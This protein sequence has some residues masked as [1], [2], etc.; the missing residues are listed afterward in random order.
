VALDATHDIP[1]GVR[2][3]YG[4]INIDAGRAVEIG[5]VVPFEAADQISRQ[6]SKHLRVGLVDDETAEA[7]ERHAG[8]A[9]LIDHGGD[10]GPHTDHVRVQPE[11]AGDILVDMRVSI[12]Q[13]GQ[14]QLAGNVDHLAGTRRQ[15][16]LCNRSDLAIAD[17]DITEPV[18]LRGRANNAATS[19]QEIIFRSFGHPNTLHYRLAFLRNLSL[20]TEPKSEAYFAFSSKARASSLDVVGGRV[21][22]G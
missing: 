22:R 17:R 20:A 12:D 8:R 1:V 16:R 13:A 18:D 3:D 14:N 7:R 6:E 19:Q 9:A 10:T 5:V 15:D 2:R 11:A 4:G 21:G